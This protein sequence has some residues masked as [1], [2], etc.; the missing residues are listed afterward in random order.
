VLCAAKRDGFCC[1]LEAH[2]GEHQA[3]S[4]D[5]LC[6]SW[7]DTGKV[8]LFGEGDVAVPGSL[9]RYLDAFMTQRTTPEIVLV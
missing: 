6:A 4:E 2:D 1:T 3:W 5:D 8:L 7:T 9:S